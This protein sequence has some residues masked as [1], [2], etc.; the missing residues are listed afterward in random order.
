MYMGRAC[1]WWFRFPSTRWRTVASGSARLHVQ[2][3]GVTGVK[4]LVADDSVFYRKSLERLLKHWNYD[5]VLAVDGAQAWDI[6]S[7]EGA[8]SLAVLD[9][10]M[11]GMTGPEVCNAIRSQKK[12]S[13]IYVILLSA[14]GEH[15]DL[16]EGFERGADDYLRKPFHELE[17]R[18]RLRVGERII[19][20]QRE[21]LEM[22]ERL[23]FQAT[24]DSMTTLWNNAAIAEVLHKEMKRAK[25]Q[26]GALSVCLVDL[27]HFKAVNDTYGHLAGDEVLKAAASRMFHA[28]RE[29]DSLGRYGG[30][31]FL[32][33][34]PGCKAVDA[35][36][37]AERMREALCGEPLLA[38]PS[39]IRVTGSFGVC[40]WAPGL[41][42]PD[43]LSRADQALYVA[44][45]TGRNRVR[46]YDPSQAAVNH[47]A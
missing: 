28:V 25:R 1:L 2:K 39:P 27:D 37:T 31:E 14:K 19:R 16:L 22:R 24:H 30:E 12:G 46:L 20:A 34:L 47:P 44:K 10:I 38:A 43:L 41:D 7:Q 26:N 32:A 17:L 5:V 42:V 13:Y 36:H 23:Q 18:A 4:V 35:I 15:E 33:V 6:L 9:Y 29:Y 3:R 8:P 40:E 11:P 21:L 45:A